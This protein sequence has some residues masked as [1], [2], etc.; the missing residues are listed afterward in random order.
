MSSGHSEHSSSKSARSV[1]PA[2]V[3]AELFAMIGGEDDRGAFFSSAS[4][5]FQSSPIFESA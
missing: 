5:A 2:A 4:S 3:L 1:L